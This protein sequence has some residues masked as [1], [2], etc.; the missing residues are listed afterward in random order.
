MQLTKEQSDQF[1]KWL[2]KL[3]ESKVRSDIER[4]W[5]GVKEG[6]YIIKSEELDRLKDYSIHIED[7]LLQ[8][9]PQSFSHWVKNEDGSKS[10]EEAKPEEKPEAHLEKNIAKLTKKAKVADKDIEDDSV[11]PYDD[12]NNDSAKK[13]TKERKEELKDREE[14]AKEGDL[15]RPVEALKS[16]PSKTKGTNKKVIVVNKKSTKKGK[17]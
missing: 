7:A 14:E 1:E 17:K 15:D 8:S 12:K 11:S 10:P 13:Q 16:K 5:D 4:L 3:P 9:F 6:G 2:S